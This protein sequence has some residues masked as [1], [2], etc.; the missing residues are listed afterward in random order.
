MARYAAP[1]TD[2]S[3]VTFKPRY[4]HFIGGEYVA[5]TKGQY[6]ENPTPVTG[7]TFTEV[8][9]GTAEDV[10][11]A[12]DAA[13]AAAPAWGKTSAAER[14]NILNKMAD[15]DRGQPR[16]RSRSPRAGRTARPCRETLAADIPL[17][18]DHL[19]YFAGAAARAGGLALRDR[20]E[21]D[22]LPL[23][24]AAG[25]R[26]A[27]HP[28]ELPDPHGDLEARPGAGRGQRG[29][30]Q[31]RRADPGLDPRAD[32]AGRRPAA[33]GRAQHRQRLRRGGRQ[34]AGVQQ[35]HPQDRVHRRDH[36]R[37]A[38]HA[39]RQREPDPGHA[40]A[41]RQEPQHLLRRRRRPSRTSSTTR[42]S[43]ASRCS[44]STRARSA[45][46]RRAR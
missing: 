41:G 1:G 27:D 2:G 3:V 10:E 40:G 16:D 46:A 37:P 29:R 34:A 32:R 8:A 6:F 30:A 7:E 43:R 31:A 26:R 45:P 11:D 23:P 33:A 17:A 21:H 36:H 25:R 14:A 24:R 9:R 20:R 38:D 12:L 35:A 19:R 28:V 39:V 22:R 42:R 4:D 15:R 5:P 44:R 13:H 18:V